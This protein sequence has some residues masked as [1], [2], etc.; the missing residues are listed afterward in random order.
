MSEHVQLFI[1]NFCLHMS[2]AKLAGSGGPGI[3]M[4]L[5]Q[6]QLAVQTGATACG[7]CM[8]FW[9]LNSGPHIHTALS[10]ESAETLDKAVRSGAP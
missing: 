7:F 1:L 9:G 3:P 8:S 10:Q 2:R 6:A 5:Q 4:S